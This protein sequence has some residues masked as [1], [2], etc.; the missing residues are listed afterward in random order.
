MRE[1]VLDFIQTLDVGG[2]NISNELPWNESGTPLY[3]KNLKKI[4]VDVDQVTSEP[5]ITTFSGLNVTNH[6]TIVRIFFAN[7]AKQVPANYSDVVAELTTAKDVDPTLNFH[8]RE[9]IVSTS[10]EAD[11]LVTI[12]ELRFIKLT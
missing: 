10:I 11:R 1:E 8:R 4:Y 5:L 3:I 2:F 7:D 12:M 9:C 6:V